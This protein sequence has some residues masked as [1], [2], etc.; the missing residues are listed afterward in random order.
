M[1]RWGR[2]IQHI[3]KTIN[4]ILL[5]LLLVLSLSSAT[6]A[7]PKQPLR[8]AVASNFT[9]VLKT[10][11]REFEAQTKIKTQIISGST[12]ALYLQI[13]HGAPF[14]IFIAA[15]SKRPSQLEQENLTVNFSRKTYAIG[16]LALFSQTKKLSLEDL[17]TPLDHF[18]IAN[19]DTAPYGKAARETLQHLD[20]WRLY[21]NK[22]ITGINVNQTFA[23]IRSQAVYSGLVAY[24][25][26]VL[27]QFEGVV[28]PSKYHQPIEQQLVVIK[29]SKHI[30]QAQQLANFLLSNQVQQE[31]VKSG[32]LALPSNNLTSEST[33]Q[34]NES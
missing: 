14:D 2:Y 26:L 20:V 16:Q 1:N 34:S 9:P 25:Q 17:S 32:Y 15:D 21:Q 6:F 10:L 19:P 31:I 12:G 22:L 4:F 30:V 33:E 8:I 24:S 27:H 11:L 5:S 23:Q 29:N 28:I 3:Q 7:A 18:A 13:K